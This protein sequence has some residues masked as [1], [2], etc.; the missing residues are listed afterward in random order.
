MANL[1]KVM[2]IGR[3]TRDPELRTLPSG[4]KKAELRLATSR[5]WKDKSGE[6]QKDVCYVDIVVWGRQ[7]EIVKSY[8]SKGRQ[9]YV[10]GRLDFQEW[11]RDGQRRSKHQIVAS[12]IKFLD[13]PTNDYGETAAQVELENNQPKDGQ[14]GPDISF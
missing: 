7:A 9:I 8:L 5:E 4:Q 3:L 1:N 12:D 14:D 2:M 6:K 13:R 10:E 11:E